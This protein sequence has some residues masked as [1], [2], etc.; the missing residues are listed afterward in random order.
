MQTD[1]LPLGYFAHD[2]ERAGQPGVVLIHDVWGLG[3][4]ARD[5]TRRLAAEGFAVLGLDL[6]SRLDEVKIENPGVWMRGLS[7]P[8]AL[9]DVQ[10]GVDFLHAHSATGARVGVTGF[11]MGGMYALLAGC[12]CT[13]LSASAPFYGL[14]SHRHGILFDEAGLDPA[15]KPSEP[16]DAVRE[17]SCPTLAFFGDRDE[18]VPMSDIDSLRE[19]MAATAQP[20]EVVVYPGAGHAFMNDTREDAFRPEDAADAWGRLV[21]F[22]GAQLG[23]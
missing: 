15:L 9:A 20:A 14:L 5:L 6:Y 12:S 8:Q 3:D 23:A 7:D 11:C 4:H 17:L 16:L 2:P 13:G 18:F 1:D 10:A 21:A 19:R 22:L